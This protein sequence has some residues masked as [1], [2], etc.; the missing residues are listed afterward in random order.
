MAVLGGGGFFSKPSK[1]L[2]LTTSEIATA[3]LSK[4]FWVRASLR[5]KASIYTNS[6]QKT[7]DVRAPGNLPN[8]KW[9]REG[10]GKK[11]KSQASNFT[12]E[13]NEENEEEE[14]NE[15]VVNLTTRHVN[16]SGILGSGNWERK[17][18]SKNCSAILGTG[19]NGG[20]LRSHAR[21]QKYVSYLR[22]FH[23]GANLA[24]YKES[25]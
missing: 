17:G 11:G 8:P 23:P 6:F 20:G 3:S 10:K 15:Q 12:Y 19:F 18:W 9:K 7:E 21:M 2:H 24:K 16:L 4:S 25:V 5:E 14:N 13:E 22:S 1:V